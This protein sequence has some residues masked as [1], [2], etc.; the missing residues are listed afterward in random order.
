MDGQGG[1]TF[2]HKADG[3]NG[4]SVILTGVLV[5]VG[6]VIIALAIFALATS[7]GA[8]LVSL[9]QY[10]GVGTLMVAGGQF[11]VQTGR[12]AAMIIEARGRARALETEAK[13]KYVAAVRAARIAPPQHESPWKEVE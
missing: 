7:L 9:A 6:L 4:W 2:E 11:V 13:G 12:G 1:I 3:P 8:A 5:G 10:I